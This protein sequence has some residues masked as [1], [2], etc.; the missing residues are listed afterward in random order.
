MKTDENNIKQDPPYPFHK[1]EVFRTQYPPKQQQ[2]K[3]PG[4]EKMRL[5]KQKPLPFPEDLD[6]K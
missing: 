4:K 1:R 2:E 5:R 6:K 3:K